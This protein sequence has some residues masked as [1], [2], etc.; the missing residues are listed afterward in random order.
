MA[1]EAID[2]MC[3]AAKAVSLGTKVDALITAVNQINDSIASI[4]DLV[5]DIKAQYEAHRQD[6]TVHNSAD[7]V[8]AV[9]K[10]DAT[11]VTYQDIS[12]L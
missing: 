4:V 11:G 1:K 12:S 3:P 6:G 7:T 8:N 10:D 2:N 5:N 9:S